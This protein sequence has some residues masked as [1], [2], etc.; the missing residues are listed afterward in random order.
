VEGTNPR[1][2][3]ADARSRTWLSADVRPQV[4]TT[5]A[6]G[7]ER[8]SESGQFN[9]DTIVLADTEL[10]AESVSVTG[11]NLARICHRAS[12]ATRSNKGVSH[13]E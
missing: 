2:T 1:H 12:W 8:C 7:R 3:A 6:L 4:C 13:D 9:T 10:A 11:V 5:L